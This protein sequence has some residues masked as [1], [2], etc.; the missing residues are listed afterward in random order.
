MQNYFLENDFREL[1]QS[2][3]KEQLWAQSIDSIIEIKNDAEKYIDHLSARIYKANSTT[4]IRY[5]LLLQ[6]NRLVELSAVFP[7]E[8]GVETLD[9]FFDS[10]SFQ[11]LDSTTSFCKCASSL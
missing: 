9:R 3:I 10:F 1:F 5:D 6:G 11:F 2:K 7:K 4:S 8:L